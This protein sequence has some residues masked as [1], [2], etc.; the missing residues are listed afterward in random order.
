MDALD[1][2]QVEEQLQRQEVGYGSV[3]R[4]GLGGDEQQVGL[5]RAPQA[6]GMSQGSRCAGLSA[7]PML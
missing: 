4:Q 2:T 5:M 7:T 1:S 3:V 6:A